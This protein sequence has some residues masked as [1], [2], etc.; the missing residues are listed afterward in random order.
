MRRSTTEYYLTDKMVFVVDMIR[1]LD[2]DGIIYYHHR[3]IAAGYIRAGEAEIDLYQGRFGCGIV[4]KYHYPLSR[5]Y[6]NIEYYLT[7]SDNID[8]LSKR[9]LNNLYAYRENM[10]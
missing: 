10:E 6:C 1:R 4:V 7:D 3:A 5:R 2:K 9:L 8:I